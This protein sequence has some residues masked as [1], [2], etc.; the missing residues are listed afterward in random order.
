MRGVA[1]LLALVLLGCAALGLGWKIERSFL[2]EGPARS[3]VEEAQ[4]VAVESI[5]AGYDPVVSRSRGGAVV[6]ADASRVFGAGG[7][8]EVALDSRGAVGTC[9]TLVA[10]GWRRRDDLQ[11]ISEFVDDLVRV[12][13][14]GRG[15]C[16]RI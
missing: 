6:T 3:G 7:R 12:L 16:E 10:S 8:I 4:I 2:I 14:L 9:V 5:L 13:D 11:Q 1:P 15:E